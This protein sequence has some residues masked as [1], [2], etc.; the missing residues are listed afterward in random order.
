MIQTV[1]EC[2]IYRWNYR[3]F[4]KIRKVILCLMLSEPMD[5]DPGFNPD[6]PPQGYRMGIPYWWIFPNG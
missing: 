3:R 2:G 6:Q 4:L 1:N 5:E